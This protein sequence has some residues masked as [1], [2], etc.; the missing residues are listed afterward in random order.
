MAIMLISKVFVYGQ[1]TTS[2]MN[3]KVTGRNGESLPGA[4]VVAVHLHS[5]TKY[6]SI[7]D[8]N[9]L[10]SIVNMRIGGP[11]KIIISYVGF[12]SFTK[13]DV[14]LRLGQILGLNV[15]L[16]EETAQITGVEIISS[17]SD[18]FDG[19]RTGAS[20]NIGNEQI[21]AIPTISRSI[22]DLTRISPQ[23]SLGNSFGGWDSRYNNI[24][25]DGANFNNNFGL[26]L[27]NLPGGD[28]QPIS[29][30][31]IEEI[32]VNIAPFDIRQSNFTG[33]NINA[34]T[35][36]GDN[37]FKGS[38]YIF[39][40]NKA[41]NGEDIGDVTI[42][43]G[44]TSTKT[45]G[46]RFG[47]PIIKNKLFFFANAEV[48]KSSFPP[49][50][51]KPCDPENGAPPD[52]NNYISRTTL[53]DLKMMRQ[54]LINTFNYDP[55]SYQGIGNLESNNHKLLGRLD[56]NLHRD[57]KLIIRYNY[58]KSIND[59]QINETS[60]PL[61]RSS[62]GRISSMSIAF[63]KANYSFLNTVSSF[64]TELNS[65]FRNNV[66]NKFL[67]TYTRI[68]DIRSSDSEE[69]PFV[70]IYK[71][72]YPYMSFG[73]ELF[74]Y[75]NDVK[76]NAFSLNDNV[77]LFLGKHIV[78]VGASFEHLYFGN[79]Y[80]R[81]GTSYYR[82]ASMDDFM[83]GKNPIAYG[84]TYPYKGV[85]DGYAE[86]NFGW[87]SVYIQDEFQLSDN[88][89]LIGG[90]RF[91]I[92]FYFDNLMGNPA[93][94]DLTFKDIEGDNLT[95]E[96]NS[97]P[98]ITPL[99]SPRLGFNWDIKG[100]RT[101][102][103]RGGTGLF[104]GRLPFVWFTNQP[105]N[106][107]I[108]QNTVEINN[109]EQLANFPFNTDPF[110]H[111]GQFSDVPGNTP[112]GTIAFVDKEF[113]MPQVWRTDLAADIKLSIWDLVITLEGLYSKDLS[114]II[115]YNANQTVPTETFAGPDN[116]YRFI[117]G[118]SGRRIN[119]GI[120]TAMVLTNAYEGQSAMFTVQWSKPATK[121][122]YGTIAYTYNITK[123]LTANPGTA[124]N[125]VWQSNPS[126]NNQNDLE[127][128][129]SYFAVPHRFVGALSYNFG[130]SSFVNGALKHTTVSLFYAGNNQGRLT[131]IY[132][133]DMNGDGNTADI[134]YVPLN[135]SEI[136]FTDIV[137]GDDVIFTAQEQQEAFWAYV[138]QDKYL[139][140][141]KGDY[142]ERY[143]TLMP[144]YN[145]LDLRII[146]D[147]LNLNYAGC[148]HNL[149]LSIDI[150]N[151]AN[152]VNS[153]WG[154]LKSQTLG[155]YAITLLRYVDVNDD[156]VPVFQLNRDGDKL[157]S[158]T[159]K[160]VLTTSS[161]WGAQIGLR[162]TF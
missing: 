142:A 137:N 128:S 10:Y 133:N 59:Q 50:P 87:G 151:I 15:K 53:T 162:Y 125:S 57:H 77:S 37:Q 100:N 43:L 40:R 46:A 28:A 90:V 25:V 33:A 69:F 121:G 20:T 112:P 74:T 21:F 105:A 108:L 22:N 17:R 82:F 147:L 153:N 93:I 11:Y 120:S 102:Q 42:N 143:G 126:I 83:D 65:I 48:E 47:G 149:Q 86:L 81:Y 155:T 139:R 85:G 45:Y 132:S 140:D 29:L 35:R 66:S 70:D 141:R 96:V 114:S 138:D 76:N 39:Y 99:V 52:P 24:T 56:Y 30:D 18:L 144:W 124:A 131:Y 44:E 152:L 27:K 91:E 103:L 60:A 160:N 129:Y 156:N 117:G 5:G 23:A 31:A 2:G 161:T 101:F 95:I 148:N 146:Q 73:Y 54:F 150:L 97:W 92:P 130:N 38:A 145:R 14:H 78:T 84:L 61:P 13:E 71:D 3:G 8:V 113:K 36:S 127:L 109:T 89:K 94:S 62:F 41:F 67:V 12:T 75:K 49:I 88:F 55:G 154:T 104:T 107:G 16:I 1:I 118:N 122:F 64:T 68:R 79:S 7:T 63:D 116:R 98:N 80:K 159:W 136:I 4:T 19:N 110:A 123:S 6:G 32:S 111:V 106:S 34:V 58:V 134:M 9:G 26:S 158:S 115:Q 135:E 72:G 157:P 51:W 119:P